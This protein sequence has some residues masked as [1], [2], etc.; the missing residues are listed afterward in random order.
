MVKTVEPY[1]VLKNLLRQHSRDFKTIERKNGKKAKNYQEA[2]LIKLFGLNRINTETTPLMKDWLLVESPVF[3]EWE[4]IIFEDIFK[5]AKENIAGWQEEELKIQFISFVLKLSFFLSDDKVGNY[6]DRTIQAD[7][8]GNFLKVKTDFMLAKGVLDLP[9]KP[10]FHF[11]EY[12]KQKDPNGDPMAQLVEAMLIAQALNEN[13]KPVY[14]ACIVGKFWDF[15]VLEN[16]DYCIS[17]SYDCTERDDLLQI[18]G[19]LRKFK[20]ILYEKLLD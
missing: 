17:K 8:D 19:I 10:Y 7:V 15:V 3:K 6:F 20:Q 16:R 14:G 11:Q 12:K 4:K 2:E 1:L 18:I 5:D 9:E 13:K